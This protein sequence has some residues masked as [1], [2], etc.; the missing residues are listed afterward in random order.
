[1]RS[2][3]SQPRPRTRGATVPEP[4]EELSAQQFAP[5]HITVCTW[6]KRVVLCCAVN[7]KYR[8]CVVEKRQ[9]KSVFEMEERNRET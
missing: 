9:G 1:M 2:T 3:L 4:P 8:A 7:D 5:V 6:Y